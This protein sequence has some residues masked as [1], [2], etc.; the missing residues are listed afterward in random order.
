VRVA[1]T[2]LDLRARLPRF[3]RKPLYVLSLVFLAGTLWRYRRQYDIVHVYQLTIMATLSALVC[4]LARKRMVV[5][6]RGIGASRSAADA[7][8]LATPQPAYASGGGSVTES[9]SF[10]GELAHLRRFG[11]LTVLATC[12]LLRWVNAVVVVLSTRSIAY[13]AAYGFSSLPV[14]LLPNGVDIARFAPHAPS[15]GAA[16]AQADGAGCVVCVARLVPVKGIDVLLRAWRLVYECAPWPRLILVGG[17]PLQ[18]LLER[19]TV[20]LELQACVEFAGEQPDAL[21]YLRRAT[22]AVLSSHGEGLSNALLE[23]MACGIPCVATRVSGSE[24]VIQHGVTGLLVEPGD[25]RA[26]ADALLTLLCD[27]ALALRYGGEARLT[28]EHHYSHEHITDR[29][30]NLYHSIMEER[31]RPA[32]RAQLSVNR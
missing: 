25:A 3:A 15:P 24:D 20:D 2:L 26:L 1:G 21:P 31:R 16:A 19:L 9:A 28:I 4:L 13:L 6:V 7:R 14:V 8:A 22:I 10:G 5:G 30:V 27:P 18:P 32:R 12:T 23:A 17:G 29:Y 11:K